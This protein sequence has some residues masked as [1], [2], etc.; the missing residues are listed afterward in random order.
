MSELQELDLHPCNNDFSVFSLNENDEQAPIISNFGTS[1]STNY[2][3]P[4]IASV[5]TSFPSGLSPEV[6]QVDEEIVCDIAPIPPKK[7]KDTFQDSDSSIGQ[8]FE[9]SELLNIVEPVI[10]PTETD[11]TT[12]EE[13]CQLFS[14]STSMYIHTFFMDNDFLNYMKYKFTPNEVDIN[15]KEALITYIINTKKTLLKRKMYPKPR[16]F[17]PDD[18]RKKIKSSF[19]KVLKS[20]VN[21]LLLSSGSKMVFDCLPQCFICNISKEMNKNVMNMEFI[22]LLSTDFTKGMKES[23]KKS[24]DYKK[25]KNNL[26]VIQYLIAHPTIASQS[27]F[28]FL[29]K[30]T[31]AN[32]MEE[33]F[34]SEEFNAAVKKLKGKESDIYIR[35]YIIKAKHYVSFYLN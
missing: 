11:L 20:R 21:Q 4:Q 29:A 3:D 18:I 1:I 27:G 12:T 33:Y 17:K 8:L 5:V 35:E 25:Y 24:I 23:K 15:D 13:P 28:N 14:K 7:K 32:I 9:N 10:L 2:L 34:T 16:K 19:H 26:E 30:R 22:Q 31:Y 6:Y